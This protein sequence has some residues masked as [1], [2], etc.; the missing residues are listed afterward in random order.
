MVELKKNLLSVALL[1]ALSMVA[2]PVYAQAA[3]QDKTDAEKKKEEEAKALDTVVVTGIRGSIERS[4]EAKQDADSI[5]EAIS[6]EDIGKLPDSSIAESIARLPGLTAQRERGR[7]TQINIR[8]LS[9]DFATTTLNGREQASTSD[10]RGVEFDQYPSELMSSVLIYKTPDASLVGQ[11]LSGTVDL[12][13]I[14]PL[15]YS[16]RVMNVNA[17]YDINKIRDQKEHG[18]RVTFSYVDQFMDNRLGLMVGLSHMDSPQP[19]YQNEAWG[20][21]DLPGYSGVQV[22]GGGKLYRFD[23]NHKRNGIAATLQFKP[24]DFYEGTLD[25]FHSK[26]EKTEIKTGVEFGTVWGSGTLSGTPTITGSTATNTSWTG[27]LPVI[28]MDSNPIDDKLTSLGW[29]NKF[30]FNEQWTM[31]LDL[32]SSKVDRDFRVLEA[33]AGVYP[34][35]TTTANVVLD[36]SG[37][38]NNYVFGTDFGNPSNI[39]LVDAGG[40]GQDGYL[41]DFNISDSVKA[42]RLDF[43]REF[44]E[45]FL[46]SLEFGANFTSRSKEKYSREAKL[47][48]VDCATPGASLAFPGSSQAFNFGGIGNLATVDAND[49]LNSGVYNLSGNYH[50]DIAA[51]NWGIDEDLTTIYVQGNIDTDLGQMPLRGNLGVQYVRAKQNSEG[52]STFAGNPGGTLVSKGTSYGNVLPSMNLSLEFASEA[53]VRFAAARQMARPRMDQLKAGMDVGICNDCSSS[54]P[55]WSGGGGNPMLKPWLANAY[56]LSFEKYFNSKA[57][58]K[59]YVSL[60]YFYKDLS[61]YIYNQTVSFDYAG[62]PL[63]APTTGQTNYPASTSGRITQPTNGEGGNIRGYEFAAQLPLDIL[64]APLSGLGLQA[65]YSDTDSSIHP[66]GPGTTEPLPGLSKYVSN[67]TAYYERHGFSLRYSRRTR[68]AFRG[69]TKGFGADL[70]VID[71]KPEV[72]Q[73]A[74]VNYSFGPGV[75]EGLSLYLQVSNIGDEPFGTYNSGDAANRPVS[76]F[77]YGRTTLLGFSYKF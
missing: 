30:H 50:A 48:I 26:F 58:N 62:Y 72:V 44:D 73:D 43:L 37:D 31:T 75:L 67:I 46:D 8:G 68:S 77:E 21:T 29:N 69:E 53:Y 20:Y 32:S 47:C 71:I 36:G 14:R 23:N 27:V 55:I 66:N 65:T 7:A 9:G 56:D 49:L 24:N 34:G 4:I 39:R 13:T 41:K 64:W 2:A 19:G 38:F 10:N 52:Y 28:R 1:T 40:W 12:R 54:G 33:Y 45:G 22:M 51:K 59:G 61:T 18:N 3:D 15:D 25:V 42:L 11:G 6:A 74:Q 17:R 5:V 76:F 57:G 60:A 16:E 35:G 63:P 70:Q